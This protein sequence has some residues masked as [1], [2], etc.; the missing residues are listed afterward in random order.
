MWYLTVLQLGALCDVNTEGMVSSLKMATT[1]GFGLMLFKSAS[2]LFR[3]MYSVIKSVPACSNVTTVPFLHTTNSVFIL[4]SMSRSLKMNYFSNLWK[5]YRHKKSFQLHLVSNIV[6]PDINVDFL[7][8]SIG[9]KRCW[10]VAR[11]VAFAGDFQKNCFVLQCDNQ[12]DCLL[13]LKKDFPPARQEGNMIIAWLVMWR[14]ILQ[15]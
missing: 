4:K 11:F 2:A 12:I 8:D 9:G 5:N 10:F 1:V 7:A 13:S 15:F 6:N 3:K 14:I